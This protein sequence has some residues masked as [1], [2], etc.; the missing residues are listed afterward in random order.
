MGKNESLHSSSRVVLSGTVVCRP[1]DGSYLAATFG[2]QLLKCI[3]ASFCASAS[4]RCQ[5][6]LH[7]ASASARR[8]NVGGD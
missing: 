8:K 6:I 7:V 4:S 1:T 5:P 3:S 2:Q